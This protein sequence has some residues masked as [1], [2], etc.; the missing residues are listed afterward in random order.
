MAP[1]KSARHPARE[2]KDPKP[3]S[4][5]NDHACP[6]VSKMLPDKRLISAMMISSARPSV[7]P[8][9]VLHGR[10]ALSGGALGAAAGTDFGTWVAIGSS[11]VPV[12]TDF[13]YLCRSAGLKVTGRPPAARSRTALSWPRPFIHR[14]ERPGTAVIQS[15]PHNATLPRAAEQMRLR[16]TS[17]CRLPSAEF[18]DFH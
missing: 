8:V 12:V 2:L 13:P 11:I 16:M 6:T 15:E 17:L 9:S 4:S 3:A 10:P 1:V 18:F 14:T 7:R 5:L